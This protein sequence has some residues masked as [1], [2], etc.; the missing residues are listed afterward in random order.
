[1]QELLA[2]DRQSQPEN[3]LPVHLRQGC[4]VIGDR[5]VFY[6]QYVGHAVISSQKAT[7]GCAGP[8]ADRSTA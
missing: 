6:R 1:V 7:R 8:S 2:D 3:A 5:E 4:C